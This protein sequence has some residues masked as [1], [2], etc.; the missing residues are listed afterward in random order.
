MLTTFVLTGELDVDAFSHVLARTTV[1]DPTDKIPE[2]SVVG[3]IDIFV[4]NL[5]REELRGIFGTL[6][7]I[8]VQLAD[9]DTSKTSSHSHGKTCETSGAHSATRRDANEEAS[10]ILEVDGC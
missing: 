2:T 8:R 4:P 3:S 7:D 5:R 9:G 1:V 6:N 10:G